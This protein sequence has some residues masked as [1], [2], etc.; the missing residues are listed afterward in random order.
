MTASK[1]LSALGHHRWR[2]RQPGQRGLRI[3][4]LDGGG[5]RG[6][7]TISLLR[8]IM[9]ACGKE[10]HDVFDIVCGTSTGGILSV[11]F[12]GQRLPVARAAK[13]YDELIIKIFSKNPWLSGAKLLF[14][15]A[16]YSESG[17]EMILRGILRDKL[18]IDTAAAATEPPGPPRA[19]GGVGASSGGGTTA[20][21]TVLAADPPKLII[22]STVI[23]VDPL[24]V[25]LWRNYGYPRDRAPTYGGSF[26]LM[27]REALRA[28]TA[29]PTYFS[30]LR[31]GDMLYCDG[32]LLANNPTALAINEAQL[33]YP[34]VPIECV[35]S[36]GTGFFRPAVNEPRLGWDTIVTQLVNSATDTETVDA[37]LRSLLP[38]HQY[39]RFNPAIDPFPIDETSPDRLEYLKE[40]ARDYFAMSPR[41]L[42]R[43]RQLCRILR[44]ES[45]PSWIGDRDGEGFL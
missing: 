6:V 38:P 17:W 14:Q 33:I 29:A 16:Q 3:L 1:L 26:R 7:M 23:N 15:Q 31:W 24:Q 25:M 37:T 36:I 30:P 13:L 39:F 18:M 12:A 35:V 40:L 11:L 5:T 10:P 9:E 45:D 4:C 44:G 2:P 21:R 42:S 43:L 8:Q 19:S 20:T 27:V 22:V 41:N 28:T 34:D 32:A